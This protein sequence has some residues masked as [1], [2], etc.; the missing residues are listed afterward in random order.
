MVGFYLYCGSYCLISIITRRFPLKWYQY[1]FLI[2]ISYFLL[3][4]F[5]FPRLD[6]RLELELI[7]CLV[8]NDD[9]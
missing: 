9:A 2:Q 5:I 6:Y 3:L 1:V 7:L 4:C 8:N